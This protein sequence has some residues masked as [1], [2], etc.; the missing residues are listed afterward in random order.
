MTA[1]VCQ[2]STAV[3]HCPPESVINIQSAFYGRK[4]GD[5]CPHFGGSEGSC[6]VEGLL[7]HYRKMCDN[8][9]F[10]FAYAHVNADADPCPSV[11]KYLEIV[12][13]CEQK[14]GLLLVFDSVKFQ[15]FPLTFPAER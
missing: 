5:I 9:P 13:S 12:Y 1:L 2:D 14:G 15:R 6:T 8:H 10:C 3:L 7:P 11:S 4:S